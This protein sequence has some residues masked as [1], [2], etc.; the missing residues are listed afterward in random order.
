MLNQGSQVKCSI[1]DRFERLVSLEHEE[2]PRLAKKKKT[3]KMDIIN[4]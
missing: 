3:H 2:I 1:T 4:E